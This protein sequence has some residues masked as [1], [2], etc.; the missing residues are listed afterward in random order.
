MHDVAK[1]YDVGKFIKYRHSVKAAHWNESKGKWDVSI[2]TSDGSTF[3]DE[4]N[5]FVNAAGVLR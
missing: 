5:V 3:L 1:K 4:C 2:Q